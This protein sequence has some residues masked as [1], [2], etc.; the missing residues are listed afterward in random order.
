MAAETASPNNALISR[1]ILALAILHTRI[2]GIKAKLILSI[3]LMVMAACYSTFDR[4][5]RV[6]LTCAHG[7]RVREHAYAQSALG[8]LP[9]LDP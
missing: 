3:Q 4:A 2:W 9:V 8:Q 7:Q 5:V 6:V 1:S